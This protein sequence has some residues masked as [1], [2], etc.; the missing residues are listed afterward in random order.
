MR[1]KTVPMTF[2]AAALWISFSLFVPASAETYSA[3]VLSV[4]DGDSLN[5]LHGT[6]KERVILFGVDTPEIGQEFGQEARDYTDKRCYKKVVG[7]E[8]HGTDAKGR[9]IAV[10][11]LPDGGNLNQELV[12]QGLAWWSDKY[13]PND[14]VLKQLHTAAKTS[15]T[16]LWSSAN[17]PIPPWIFRNGERGVSAQIKPKE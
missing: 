14:T 5:V 6:T 8:A 7:I 10:V 16:G 2:A 4:P 1:L 17:K 15:R 3:T 13:A 12:K 11:T 9:I